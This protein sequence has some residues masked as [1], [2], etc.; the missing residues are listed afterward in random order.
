[1]LAGGCAGVVHGRTRGGGEGVTAVDGEQRHGGSRCKLI[2]YFRSEN[3][4]Y[5]RI[6]N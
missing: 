6:V 1:M 3:E 4:N 5:K 2:Y